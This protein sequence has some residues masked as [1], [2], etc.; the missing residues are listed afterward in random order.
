MGKLTI[1]WSWLRWSFEVKISDGYMTNVLV[2]LGDGEVLS[3]IFLQIFFSGDVHVLFCECWRTPV[4]RCFFHSG[5]IENH[6]IFVHNLQEVL[7]EEIKMYI[8]YSLTYLWFVFTV[9]LLTSI[10][11]L[12][13]ECRILALWPFIQQPN[14]REMAT[15]N[16]PFIE[17]SPDFPQTTWK[18]PWR[19]VRLPGGYLSEESWWSDKP[20]PAVPS[21]NNRVYIALLALPSTN[22]QGLYLNR[23][24]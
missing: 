22:W 15:Q 10:H 5:S 13:I 11:Q 21:W 1:V 6:Q 23:N 12:F 7:Y 24:D 14:D 17:D 18:C 9:N 3:A 19:H 2:L 4:H 20:S 8:T 16:H